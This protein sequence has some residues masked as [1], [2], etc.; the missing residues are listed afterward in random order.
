MTFVRETTD[1]GHDYPH[2]MLLVSD[3]PV[4]TL[5]LR[6]YRAATR[7]SM[8]FLGLVCGSFS[9]TIVIR[10]LLTIQSVTK[11]PPELLLEGEPLVVQASPT[12]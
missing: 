9:S 3:H 12:R 2:D 1:L 4:V 6:V 8:S 10:I 5:G 7:A 11:K